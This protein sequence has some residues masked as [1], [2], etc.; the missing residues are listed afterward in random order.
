MEQPTRVLGLLSSLPVPVSRKADL[1]W[2]R[3]TPLREAIA[4]IFENP[5]RLRSLYDLAEVRILYKGTEEPS[6]VYYLAG[7]FMH[8]LGAGVPL[9]IARGV[10]PE[11]AG[12]AHVALSGPALEAEI[13]I[14][15][16]CTAEVTV[17]G[18]PPQVT[19]LPVANEAWALRQEL[20]I[21]SRDAVFEDA[22]GLA[23]LM[24]GPG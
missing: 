2:A 6:S 3:L 23:N 19:V 10:G 22:T 20:G 14:V 21:E 5:K 1:V 13:G 8:T 7:W 24:R 4:Q 16:K 12:I 9:R 18:E 17:N 11:Y 15:E